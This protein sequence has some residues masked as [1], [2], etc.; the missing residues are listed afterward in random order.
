MIN[1]TRLRIEVLEERLALATSIVEHNDVGYFF[2]SSSNIVGRYDIPKKNWLASVTLQ[3]TTSGPT[4]AH[5]DSDGIYAGFG[6]AIYRYKSDGTGRTH[7][8]NLQSPAIAIHS[9]GNLLFLNHSISL[10]SRFVSIN[11]NNNTVIDSVETY[12]YS[13]SGSSIAPSLNTLYGRS[14][15]ISPPDITYQAYD[16]NGRFIS[17]KGDSPYHGSYPDATRTWV[18]PDE[19][20]VVDDAGIIYATSNLTYSNRLSRI[21]DI[22]FLGGQLPFVLFGKDVVAYSRTFLPTGSVS[23]ATNANKIFVSND[24][25]IVFFEDNTVSFG[26][27]TQSI[28]LS[29]FNPPDPNGPIDPTG[30]AYTPD[31]LAVS[32]QGRVL[33]LSKTHQNIFRWNPTT[34][35]YDQSIGLLGSPSYA[36]YQRSSDTIYVLYS[37]GL[38][39]QIDLKVANPKEIPFS[40]LPGTPL[41]LSVADDFVFAADDSGAWNSHYVISPQGTIISSRDWNYF[42]RDYVWSTVNRRMYFFR[43]D[44]SPNDL[45]YESI[46]A[47]GQLQQP[48]D[49]P[50]HDSVGWTHPIRLSPDGSV[51]A[52]GSGMLVDASTL[53][54]KTYAL[55][56]GFADA[57]WFAGRLLSVRT[58]A[59]IPQLQ[60]WVGPTYELSE[61][62]QWDNGSAF[63][64][65]AIT[66]KRLL[67][68]NISQS[69]I[70][71]FTI[72]DTEL[73]P[74][75]VNITWHNSA[76]PMDVDDDKTM[77]PLD[78]L[79]VVNQINQ[80]GSWQTEGIGE[81]FCDVDKDGSIS[82]L[83][84][85][86][87]I[88]AINSKP[89]GEGESSVD[90]V[91]AID[92]LFASDEEWSEES[93]TRNRRTLAGRN[94]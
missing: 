1:K 58:I 84:A 37:S 72:L 85:L 11:K 26:Y 46:D 19:T 78:V 55:G 29:D 31:W 17:K 88:N 35:T 18:F 8:I 32:A 21:Q 67:V 71:N 53:Q 68:T 2:D 9:D 82:P 48:V 25:V 81:Y 33:L 51:V 16:D 42:S 3:N 24:S 23:L 14:I 15:G 66:S 92:Y 39:Y 94:R 63:S 61:V 12:I 89:L 44:T 5:V 65:R 34:Q 86:V 70:P 83:D 6:Q 41:G 90:K 38:I 57:T 43:D 79:T 93:T 59:G 28:P 74:A 4:V 91:S 40:R 27:R 60:E 30:L 50:Y 22:D 52:L 76:F 64:V 56:N 77:S 69:G 54:K 13:L 36:A 7:L 49:S 10:Y 87:I 80:F 73:N 45:L 62:K 75:T 47:S 20:K